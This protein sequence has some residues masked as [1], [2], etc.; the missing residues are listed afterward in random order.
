MKGVKEVLKAKK[1]NVW[2][3]SDRSGDGI[4]LWGR[5]ASVSAKAVPVTR[6]IM[7]YA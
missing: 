6:I 7:N 4:C 3:F 5:N 1:S 2:I